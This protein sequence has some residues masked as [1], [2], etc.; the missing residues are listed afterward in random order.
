MRSVFWH[1]G[2]GSKV[3]QYGPTHHVL[4]EMNS[5]ISSLSNIPIKIS[6]KIQKK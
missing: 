1:Q 4:Q 6:M 3:I 5:V 2:K